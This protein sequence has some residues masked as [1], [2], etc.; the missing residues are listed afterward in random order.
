MTT[1]AVKCPSC[2]SPDCNEYRQ[3][4]FVCRHCDSTFRWS[5]PNKQEV[6]HR[7]VV[8]HCGEKPIGACTKCGA[9]MCHKHKT[10]FVELLANWFRF[11]QTYVDGAPEKWRKLATQQGGLSEC[12]L[13][14]L[15]GGEEITD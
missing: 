6:V 10:F 5:D 13:I 2:G 8:C 1:H 12:T 15:P 7:S 14:D 4:S 9:P 3:D 11:K